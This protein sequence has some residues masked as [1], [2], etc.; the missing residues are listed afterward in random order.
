MITDIFGSDIDLGSKVMFAHRH[1]IK[2]G[3][4]TGMGLF[5]DYVVIKHTEGNCSRR[6]DHVI[7]IKTD[8]LI[9]S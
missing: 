3:T 1:Q 5:T 8:V 9:S 6:G 4:V 7:L 2:V